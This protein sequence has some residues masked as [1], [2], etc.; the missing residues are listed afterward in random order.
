MNSILVATDLSAGSEQ[1]VRRAIVFAAQASAR[2]ICLHVIDQ[3]LT[4]EAADSRRRE[5]E[6]AIKAQLAGA[7]DM[8]VT[9]RIVP[10]NHV[11]A[12]MAAA[13]DDSVDLVVIGKHH[14]VTELDLFRG[15]TGERVL[16]LGTRPVLMVKQAVTGPYRRVMI[17]TD[18]SASARTAVEFAIRTLP[19]A[20]LTLVHAA[21]RAG[22]GMAERLESQFGEFLAGLDDTPLR[23]LTEE[24]PPV[25]TLMKAI[26][27]LAPDLVVI[28][29]HGRTGIGPLQIGTVAE[30]VLSQSATDVLAV[31]A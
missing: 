25:P 22:A 3:S 7:H 20:E 16:K 19:K 23:R 30:R 6:A 31:R 29:T 1:A 24:G 17:A 10:G 4:G 5:A 11:D 2:V 13:Q 28:G 9:V 8:A 12:I 14:S 27:R 15:T 18:F 26:E 21:P